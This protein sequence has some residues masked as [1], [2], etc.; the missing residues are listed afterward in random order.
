M[1]LKN[2]ISSIILSSSACLIPH[3][4]SAFLLPL[5]SIAMHIQTVQT[6]H[7]NIPDVCATDPDFT[8]ATEV[9]FDSQDGNSYLITAGITCE[10]NKNNP[11]VPAKVKAFCDGKMRSYTGNGYDV[12]ASV[13]N[14]SVPPEAF[15]TSIYTK[16]GVCSATLQGNSLPGLAGNIYSCNQSTSQFVVHTE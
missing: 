10:Y 15:I 9:C 1:Q 13:L 7:S 11:N 6:A 3:T 14:P 16:M 4:V 2:I 5:N 8:P 12:V